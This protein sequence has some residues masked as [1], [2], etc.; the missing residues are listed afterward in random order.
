MAKRVQGFVDDDGTR[1]EVEVSPD[2]ATSRKRKSAAETALAKV[3]AIRKAIG[4]LGESKG[5]TQIQGANACD[6]VQAAL[7]EARAKLTA[8]DAEVEIDSL[9]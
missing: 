3:K 9:D 7:E 5:L 1:T 8:I 4:K 6:K 2:P